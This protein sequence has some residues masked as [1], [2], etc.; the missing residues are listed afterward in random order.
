MARKNIP[1]YRSI[2]NHP[3]TLPERLLDDIG[4]IMDSVD[5]PKDL[6]RYSA[7]DFL[8]AIYGTKVSR[9]YKGIEFVYAA[10]LYW[11]VQTMPYK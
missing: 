11:L 8:K 7:P 6:R 2:P 1:V 3:R 9:N 10:D 4:C 5:L